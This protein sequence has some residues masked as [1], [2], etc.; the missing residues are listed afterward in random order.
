[1]RPQVGIIVDNGLLA[2]WQALALRTISEKYELLLYNCTNSRPARRR[3]R[4]ALYYLLNLLAIRNRETRLV[5]F[6]ADVPLKGSVDF[7]A[8]YRG[9]WQELPETL[10]QQ[11]AE[12]RPIA[13]VKFGMGLLRVPDKSRLAAPILSYHHGD[14][15]T[16]RGRPAG[17]H[18]M[19]SGADRMGQIVQVLAN[20]LDAGAVVAFAETR[21]HR[22]SY[23]TTLLE[24]YRISPLL[25]DR[26]IANLLSGEAAT[27]DKGPVYRLPSNAQVIAFCARLAGHY[28]SRLLYG[29]FVE[30]NWQVARCEAPRGDAAPA[31]LN[32][33]PM[34]HWTIQP[35]PDGYRFIA[36]PFFD[37]RR[38][39]ILVE[40]MSNSTG[41]GTILQIDS[42]GTN[43]IFD[44]P[45][46]WS[47]PATISIDDAHFII[48]EAAEAGPVRLFE[49][50]G[51]T[52]VPVP[53][54]RVGGEPRLIDPTLVRR[55]GH[56]YL[57][58]N[59]LEEGPGVLRLWH[60]EDLL[61]PLVEHPMSPIRISPAGSRMAGAIVCR[62]NST[63]RFGQD[64]TRDYGN[65]VLLFEIEK[66]SPTEYSE[67]Q[68]DQFRFGEVFGPHTVNFQGSTVLFDFY[69]NAVSPA[70]GLRRLMSRLGASGRTRPSKARAH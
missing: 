5:Q 42:E 39:G 52:M 67:V 4:H 1:M 24:A 55:G 23:R 57:F 44:E 66:L 58:G 50:V 46:H 31:L 70:A 2:R 19:Q 9:N 62:G 60:G 53:G 30:K 10:L 33:P 8:E 48:P 14:P 27:M 17:F 51:D 40:G 28:A 63:W 20:E 43:R 54:F 65:G 35:T 26:A 11:I 34:K 15:R 37:P 6:P 38:N 7:E 61:T 3:P 25:L 68:R 29:A 36:D 18:E 56:L 47:Y 22:H 16:F 49:L 41:L 45:G 21:I 64:W 59:R 69:R 32:F 13:L 12:D